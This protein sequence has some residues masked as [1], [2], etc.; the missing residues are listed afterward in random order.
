MKT[1]QLFAC[2]FLLVTLVYGQ[3]RIDSLLAHGE[4]VRNNRENRDLIYHYKLPTWHYSL[5]YADLSGSMTGDDKSRDDR[6]SN[7]DR[8][9]L[10]FTPFY[11]YVL[12]GEQKTALLQF[13]V[14][15]HY[16]YQK[17]KL[18]ERQGTRTQESTDKKSYFRMTGNLNKYIVDAWFLNFHGEGRFNYSENTYDY[19]KE[20]NGDV[21]KDK[22]SVI[23]R[24]FYF[25]ANLGFGYGRIR[26]VTPVFR[27]LVFNRRLTAVTG[28]KID[29]LGDLA[30]AF[31]RQAA[32]SALYERSVKYFYYSLPEAIRASLKNLDAWQL[33][34]LNDSFS[35]VIGTRFEGSETRGGLSLNYHKKS[36][37]FL[38]RPFTAGI[39]QVGLF[40]E[41]DYYHNFT[42][43][44]QL[45]ATVSMS[46]NKVV[47]TSPA[48]DYSG[49][50]T[51]ALSNLFNLTDRLLCTFDLAYQTMFISGGKAGMES[52]ERQINY[53]SGLSFLYRIENQIYLTSNMNWNKI[54]LNPPGA[55]FYYNGNLMAYSNYQKTERW[56]VYF[57]LRY[58]FSLGVY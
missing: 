51:M 58:Y 9:F 44:Y 55:A 54:K 11:K 26:N 28:R 45:G 18:D 3:N 42:P 40:L 34:Y 14:S 30:V 46:L 31:T 35:E 49:D 10:A 1:M 56:S 22:R 48:Y 5:L 17:D 19:R 23:T 38:I 32:Y 47:D 2:V 53:S 41:H 50:M 15:N 7:L 57:G 4:F 36:G 24:E 52:W 37:S 25:N 13:S 6:D 21:L 29:N 20:M 27:A 39:T 8:Y 43:Y 16:N 12:Q 33:M